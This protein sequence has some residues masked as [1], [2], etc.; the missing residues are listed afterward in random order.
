MPSEFWR[1]VVDRVAEEVPD[2]LLLAE[3]FWLLEGYFVR[4]LGMHR[5]YNSAFMHMLKDEDNL[6][7]RDVIKNT[8]AFEPEILKRYVNFMSNPDEETAIEQFGDGDKFFGI[9]MLLVTMPGLPMFA[10]GQV[11]GFSEKYGM[12]YRRAR[13]DEDVRHDLIER[14]EREIGPLIKKRYLFA[15]VD[16]FFLFDFEA[17]HGEVNQNVFA[18]SNCSG[19]ER[20]LLVHNNRFEHTV[21]R[22]NLSTHLEDNSRRTSLAEALKLDRSGGNVVRFRD[23]TSGLEFVVVKDQFFDEG[24]H[25]ELDGYE[26]HAFTGFEVVPDDEDGTL[27]ALATRLQ[28]RGVEKLEDARFDIRNRPLERVVTEIVN[29]AL[30][31]KDVESIDT[32]PAEE[33]AELLN[34]ELTDLRETLNRLSSNISEVQSIKGVGKR[35]Q[36][37]RS[38]RYKAAVAAI[39]EAMAEPSAAFSVLV[40]MC[41]VETLVELEVTG[42]R[43]IAS[44]V[45]LETGLV[46]IRTVEEVEAIACAFVLLDNPDGTPVLSRILETEHFETALIINEFAGTTYY[47]KERF[48]IALTSALCLDVLALTSLGDDQTERETAKAVARAY[49]T[50]KRL[51]AAHDKSEYDWEKLSKGIRRHL[52]PDT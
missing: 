47:N 51:Y 40:A 12:E 21:G 18:Y 29:A 25:F 13:R 38:K 6:K 34:L 2:T 5:V 19:Q 42:I 23:V 28:G 11:E 43:R 8:L 24:L 32:G 30:D 35:Y 41:F 39:E 49:D 26:H 10:H 48:E 1:E 36:W 15:E 46:S 3:A 33:A 9:A 44:N 22:I 50:Y 14:F 16:N 17:E 7:Y 45:M 31:H 37:P 4:T 27:V 52:I 20:A